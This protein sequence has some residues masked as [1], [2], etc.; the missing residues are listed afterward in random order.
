M[1]LNLEPQVLRQGCAGGTLD[2]PVPERVEQAV[3]FVIDDI[4]D[5][6][7]ETKVPGHIAYLGG[8]TRRPAQW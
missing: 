1:I 8:N 7:P 5:A 3:V 4:G 2:E 6:D